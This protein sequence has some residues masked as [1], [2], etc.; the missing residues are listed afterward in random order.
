V[1]RSLERKQVREEAILREG[2]SDDV[3]EWILG[4]VVAPKD[5]DGFGRMSSGYSGA[6]VARVDVNTAHFPYIVKIDERESVDR[7]RRNRIRIRGLHNR[8]LPAVIDTRQLSVGISAI[9]YEPVNW[10]QTIVP[11]REFYRDNNNIKVCQLLGK[12]LGELTDCWYRY[13]EA[14]SLRLSESGYQIGIKEKAEILNTI[15]GLEKSCSL[16]LNS[17]GKE[18]IINLRRFLNRKPIRGK[19]LWQTQMEHRECLVHG[20]LNSSNFFVDVFDES[21][22]TWFLIDFAHTEPA[23]Y[24]MDFAKLEAEIKFFLMD[25]WIADNL[26]PKRIRLWIEFENSL[27]SVAFG[28]TPEF[29]NRRGSSDVRKAYTVI[30]RIR[31]LAANVTD[32]NEI[33][34]YIALLYHTLMA[35]RYSQEFRNVIRIRKI[36]SLYCANL[37]LDK[38]MHLC[39]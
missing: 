1:E 6:I 15:D 14:N 38:L 35:L 13:Q 39:P 27:K 19:D 37:L 28:S 23:H 17:W 4:R 3:L 9:V 29:P 16:Y 25:N 10:R 31:S 32:F 24:L 34:Y 21:L 33:D 18:C 30:S 7:E 12:M 11:F 8:H 5:V 22:E 36:F 2:V 26:N 20:D